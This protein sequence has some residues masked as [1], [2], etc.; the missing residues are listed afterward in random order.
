MEQYF[1]HFYFNLLISGD[2]TMFSSLLFNLLISGDGIMF[3]STN[4]REYGGEP[5]SFLLIVQIRLLEHAK[6]FFQPFL[7]LALGS[8]LWL[9]AQELMWGRGLKSLGFM[10]RMISLL[11]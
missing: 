7:N 1:N 11:N 8:K 4:Q 5:S 6:R 2:G 9:G 10:L 3:S